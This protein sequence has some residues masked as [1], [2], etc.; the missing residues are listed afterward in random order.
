MSDPSCLIQCPLK[1]AS[2]AAKPCLLYMTIYCFRVAYLFYF[3]REKLRHFGK[4]HHLSGNA[5]EP[6]WKD[7]TAEHCY[8][9]EI[10][11]PVDPLE[12]NIFQ[13]WWFPEHLLS[14]VSPPVVT[15]GWAGVAIE[16]NGRP[17][18]MGTYEVVIFKS[19]E[20][21][22]SYY[23]SVLQRWI[24]TMFFPGGTLMVFKS[25]CIMWH[26]YEKLQIDI[27]VDVVL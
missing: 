14:S 26:R 18:E 4:V 25:A 24:F 7:E 1:I 16:C 27:L 8:S 23:S 12:Y 11:P 13:E 5:L 3:F 9:V 22:F 6:I 15:K 20:G 19:S 21:D 2:W 17:P 10:L